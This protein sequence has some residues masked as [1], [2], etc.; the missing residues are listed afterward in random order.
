MEDNINITKIA[1][2]IGE[3]L[4]NILWS[5]IVLVVLL[6]VL[7]IVLPT[8]GGGSGVEIIFIVPFSF[9]FPIFV[10]WFFKKISRKGE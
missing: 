6:L 3:I 2:R 5:G 1:S 4:L 7:P 10:R 9:L 8:R